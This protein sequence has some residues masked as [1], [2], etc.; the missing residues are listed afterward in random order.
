MKC[1]TPISHNTILRLP[2][3]LHLLEEMQGRGHER[4][5]SANTVDLT[6]KDMHCVVQNVDLRNSLFMLTYYLENRM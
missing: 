1:K 3:Y 6:Q 4:M 2:R 5:V